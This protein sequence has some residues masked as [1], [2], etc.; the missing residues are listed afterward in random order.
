MNIDDVINH[1]SGGGIPYVDHAAVIAESLGGDPEV[2]H[3][4]NH[5]DGAAT[6]TINTYLFA[7]IA[8]KLKGG[9]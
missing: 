6:T 4:L 3:R 5:L 7:L 1:L 9:E 8:K 2:I